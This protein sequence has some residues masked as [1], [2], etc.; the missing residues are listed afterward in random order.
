ME[1]SKLKDED[2]YTINYKDRNILQSDKAQQRYPMR[3]ISVS[4]GKGGVGKT[5]TVVH[6]AKFLAANDL[7][8]LILDGDLGLANV[9]I[10]LG[11]EPKYNIR[12]VLDGSVALD[13]IILKD[14]NGIDV[15][16][17]G[18]GLADLASLSYSQKAVVSSYLESLADRYDYVIVDTAAG[19]ADTVLHFNQIVQ[20]RVI[21]CTSEPHS[22]TDA[23]ALIKVLSKKGIKDFY[24]LVNMVH[25]VAEGEKIFSNMKKVCFNFLSIDLHFLGSIPYDKKLSEHIL[26]R[27]VGDAS[28][29]MSISGQA[30][31]KAGRNLVG[32]FQNT[33]SQ[34]SDHNFWQV[35]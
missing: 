26:K 17:T 1:Y 3:S 35:L 16:P 22:L 33:T 10:V 6:L 11:L 24:L 13:K 4:S 29:S 5:L 32:V 19:I 2:F 31:S 27:N 18:S 14:R 12:D 15:I 9:D 28:L 34:Q 25:S 7:R 21:V 23:Y 20:K 8:I 30:W